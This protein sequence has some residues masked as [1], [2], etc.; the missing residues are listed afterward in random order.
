MTRTSSPSTEKYID[1]Y[2]QTLKSILDDSLNFSIPYNQR[3]WAWDDKKLKILWDDIKKTHDDFYEKQSVN[4]SN[5]WVLKPNNND[6]DPHF[7]GA[8]VFVE[9]EDIDNQKILEVVD[10]QQRLT[11]L[12]MLAS[13][14]RELRTELGLIASTASQRS[15]AQTSIAESL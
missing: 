2:T 3:P 12:T 10:G 6:I 15:K 8:F 11:S 1:V 13:I 4:D 9:A 14:I 5:I 7:F